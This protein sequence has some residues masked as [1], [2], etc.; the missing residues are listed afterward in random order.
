MKL[1]RGERIADDHGH[2]MAARVG[3]AHL[4]RPFEERAE[5]DGPQREPYRSGFDLL[6]LEGV[7]DE[8]HE[9]LALAVRRR[10]QR[11]RLIAQ[12]AGASALERPQG[13]EDGGEQRPHFVAELADELV[14]PPLLAP[15]G[16]D[17]VF[18]ALVAVTEERVGFLEPAGGH[19]EGRQALRED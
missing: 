1:P 13:A 2:A 10:D 7:V 16:L 5:L 3:L 12:R 17:L 18:Q 6:F 14:L 11:L 8:M 19:F 9:A 4:D 15:R